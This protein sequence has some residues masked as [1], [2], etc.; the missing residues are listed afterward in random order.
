MWFNDSTFVISTSALKEV[1]KLWIGFVDVV[2]KAYFPVF[3]TFGATEIV[4]GHPL[5]KGSL[6]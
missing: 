2:K 3:S 1:F 5:T 4:V 6:S